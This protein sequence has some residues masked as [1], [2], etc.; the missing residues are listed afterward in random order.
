MESRPTILI[1]DDDASFGLMLSNLM[2]S[3][4]FEV[5]DH[6]VCLG[7]VPLRIIGGRYNFC[8]FSDAGT[9]GFEVLRTL[10]KYKTKCSVVLMSGS[11][12]RMDEAELLAKQL[13]LNVMGIL[14]KPFRLE[15]VK[16]VLEG[17]KGVRSGP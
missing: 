11:P 14:H 17:A 3:L 2:R 7:C 9:N 13:E 5:L 16:R 15:D 4:E 1:V 6:A 8:G 10:V 12:S